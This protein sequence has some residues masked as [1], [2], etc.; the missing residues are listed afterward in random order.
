MTWIWNFL[1]LA[2]SFVLN[3]IAVAIGAECFYYFWYVTGIYREELIQIFSFSSQLFPYLDI[4]DTVDNRIQMTGLLLMI[5]TAVLYFI[6]PY[7]PILNEIP[8]FLND[9]HRVYGPEHKNLQEALELLK[10]RSVPIEKYRFYIHPDEGH[11]A[12]ANGR[13]DITIFNR[14]VE[15]FTPA[16][17]AGLICHEMGHHT[18]GD[19]KFLTI[20]N[21]FSI[22][23]YLFL[24]FMEIL[25]RFFGLC[26]YF[27][28]KPIAIFFLI[29]NWALG[30]LVSAYQFLLYL[31]TR[32]FDLFFSRQIEYAADNYAVKLGFGDELADSLEHLQALYGDISFFKALFEDHPRTKSRIKRL[33]GKVENQ[34]MR[35]LDRSSGISWQQRLIR[36]SGIGRLLTNKHRLY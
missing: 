20:N 15:E 5:S 29:L 30:L 1:S 2:L 21:A 19:T 34:F 14:V 17:I 33:R 10:K 22:V 13:N 7:I 8:H 16:E 36:D 12:Y 18:H 28:F 11:N 25:S 23:G 32:I 4:R 26:V 6:L 24:R 35:E 31:P 3:Y 27:P 9:Q